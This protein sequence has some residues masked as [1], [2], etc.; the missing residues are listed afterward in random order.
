MR[1]IGMLAVLVGSLALAAACG[2]ASSGDPAGIA[3]PTPGEPADAAAPTPP[4]T[5]RG[6]AA[7]TSG[8]ACT[9]NP[10]AL[11]DQGPT[12]LAKLCSRGY[13]DPITHAFCGATPPTVA[14]VTDAL[15]ALG[16]DFQPG[17]YANGLTS[18]QHGNPSFMLS[19]QSTSLTKRMVSQLNPRAIFFTPPL[20][21]GRMT[22]PPKPNPSYE[23]MAFTRG[24]QAIELLAKDPTM[25]GGKGDI[26]FFFL[27]YE[28]A[29][30]SAPGGCTP[31][32]LYTPAVESNFVSWSLYDD[33]DLKDT[34][35]D[36]RQCHQPAGPG[37]PRMLRMQEL[38]RPWQHWMY[39]DALDVDALRADFH[40]AHGTAEAYGGIP[41]AAMDF[42]DVQQLEA[43][44]ENN[45]FITQPNEFLGKAIASELAANGT[46]ATW[47]SLYQGSAAGQ[48]IPVPYFAPSATDPTLV[49]AL[50]SQY[51]AVA[52]GTVPANQ[53]GDMKNVFTDPA[54]R[55]MTHKPALG[56]S[57][58]QILTQICQQCHNSRLDQT[59]SRS[60]FNVEIL[61]T[62]PRAEKDEAIRRINLPQ[63]QCSHMPP[64]R[65][66][67]L[68][69]AEIALAQAELQK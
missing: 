34:S 62:L 15:K 26:R 22:G 39:N 35:L 46:S 63:D 17:P 58:R 64:T 21:R 66:S 37:T 44:V 45:G 43:F 67:E 57:G 28:Q 50:G 68:D 54:Q 52:A 29:C 19:A 61:D 7:P 9:G 18:G 6:D 51:A 1:R 20:A 36:C 53:L 25:N 41:G 14:S 10:T 24:D 8:P 30:N 48:F 40:G 49:Q 60:L 23:A 5:P 69:A 11:L 65:F 55:A 32:D 56:L 3:P 4:A 13:G 16:L 42:G 38:Q 27:K 47:Q 12:Q 33:E 31:G 2:S 59:I